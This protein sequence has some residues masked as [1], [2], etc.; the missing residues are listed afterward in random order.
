L[1]IAKVATT[2]NTGPNQPITFT[3][4]IV[5]RT[6]GPVFIQDIQDT[7][8]N[9]WAWLTGNPCG[10]DSAAVACSQPIGPFGGGVTWFD[11]SG[12]I[13]LNNFEQLNL[14]VNGSYVGPDPSGQPWCNRYGTELIVNVNGSPLI[15]TDPVDACVTIQ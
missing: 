6:G 2:Y 1:R 3:I 8:P 4:C 5:N 15:Q 9:Q 11:S 7:F 10:S 12:P 13:T 14:T